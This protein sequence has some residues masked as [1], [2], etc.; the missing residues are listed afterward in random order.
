MT[1]IGETISR[2][3]NTLK[4]SKEDSFL[5]DRLVYSMIMKYAKLLI[6]RQDSENKLMKF[7]SLFATL[8]CVDLIEVDKI[9]ACCSGIRSKCIIRR[10]KDKLPNL[11]EGSFGPLLRSVTS[12]DSSVELVKTYPATYTSI[13]NSTNF[14]YNKNKYY[15]YLNGYLYFPNIEWEAVKVE[16]IWDSDISFFTCDEE[17]KCKTR[18]EQ[19]VRIPEH[20]FAEIEQMVVK[21]LLTTAQL[22][23]NGAD[24][25]QN[26]LR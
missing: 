26:V 19:T 1:T 2:V 14:K 3:K 11:L 5:T 17:E 10:T 9:E 23:S 25:S 18:Q 8:P 15:W 21:E 22:P 6:K 13:S 4:A 16:G 20:L 24:D 7:Q 12:I